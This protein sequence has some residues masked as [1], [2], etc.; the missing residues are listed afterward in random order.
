MSYNSIYVHIPFCES[1]CNYCDY[2]AVCGHESRDGFRSLGKTT[3]ED[4][5]AACESAEKGEPRP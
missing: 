2:R 5:A 3:L 4:I 1:R